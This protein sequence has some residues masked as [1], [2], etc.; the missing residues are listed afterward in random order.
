MLIKELD[1]R[2]DT[3]CRIVFAKSNRIFDLS[4]VLGQT[5]QAF[6]DERGKEKT[7]LVYIP[8]NKLSFASS[9]VKFLTSTT[10]NEEFIIASV[11][12]EDSL[13]ELFSRLEGVTS[14]S[15]FDITIEN[16]YLTVFFRFHHDA[17]S[18]ISSQLVKTDLLKHLVKEINIQPASGLIERC[19]HKSREFPVRVLVYSIPFAEIKG[20]NA[21]LLLKQGAIAES[22]AVF[23]NTVEPRLIFYGNKDLK[24]ELKPLFKNTF[25]Y[26]QSFK[27]LRMET[28]TILNEVFN[29][30]G[31]KRF[32]IFFKKEGDKIRIIVLVNKYDAMTHITVSF[33]YYSKAGIPVELNLSED[34]V[35]DVWDTL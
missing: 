29:S 22:A 16:G 30:E 28:F 32:H 20:K 15:S 5:F 7:C 19:D 35:S 12:I 21:K 10:E 24:T 13:Y 1:K 14:T 4:K 31:L 9:S 8:K 11:P 23:T 33:A 17:I 27:S 6:L 26:Q 25:I 18:E 3:D 34:Y 2:L